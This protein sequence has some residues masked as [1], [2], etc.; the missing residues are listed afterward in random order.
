MLVLV[1]GPSGYRTVDVRPSV[2]HAS[3][4]GDGAIGSYILTTSLTIEVIGRD[5]VRG[6]RREYSRARYLLVIY[7]SIGAV[8]S[9]TIDF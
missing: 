4:D 1:R 2:H 7:L 5:A 9:A 6:G 3:D 8:L